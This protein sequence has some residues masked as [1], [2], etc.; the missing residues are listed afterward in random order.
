MKDQPWMPLTTAK[1]LALITLISCQNL[2]MRCFCRKVDACTMAPIRSDPCRLLLLLRRHSRRGT[3][4]HILRLL[5]IP[6]ARPID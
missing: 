2:G 1:L 6:G 3:Q 4:A 5:Q